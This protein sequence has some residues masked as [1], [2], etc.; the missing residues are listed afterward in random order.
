MG[1]FYIFEQQDSLVG[2]MGVRMGAKWVWDLKW[3]REEG[4]IDGLL[5]IINMVTLGTAH[6]P[7][8]WMR[9]YLVVSYSINLVYHSLFSGGAVNVGLP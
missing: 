2:S 1:L 8:S 9:A 4:L 6:E 5:I 3:V 7:W